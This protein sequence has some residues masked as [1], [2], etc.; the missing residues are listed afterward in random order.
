MSQLTDKNY[1]NKVKYR[2]TIGNDSVILLADN[3]V[4]KPSKRLL[5]KNICQIVIYNKDFGFANR[6]RKKLQIQPDAFG[7]RLAKGLYEKDIVLI[8]TTDG[9]DHVAE[10]ILNDDGKSYFLTHSGELISFKSVSCFR[11]LGTTLSGK[12]LDDYIQH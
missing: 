12:S 3:A 1:Y 5:G 11:Y 9:Q 10:A 6:G 8:Q 4:L 7:L 2:T